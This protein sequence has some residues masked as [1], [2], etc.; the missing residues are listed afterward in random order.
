MDCITNLSL[1]LSGFEPI[2]LFNY[3]WA[4]Q[5]SK[6]MFD[7][8]QYEKKILGQTPFSAQG[9]FLLSNLKIMMSFTENS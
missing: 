8:T 4:M 7:L 9:L 6:I 1:A 5:C 3:L 2:S